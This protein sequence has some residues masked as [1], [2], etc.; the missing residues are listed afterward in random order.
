MTIEEI[1]EYL[2]HRHPFLLIDRIVSFEKG[3]RIAAALHAKS[4][5]ALTD[6]QRV[7]GE[8]E[9]NTAAVP[10]GMGTGA[11]VDSP[12]STIEPLLTNESRPRSARTTA[13]DNTMP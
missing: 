3:T 1:K 8:R 11:A 7:V 10:E 4:A 2:P 12:T 6:C 13:Y 9:P 5:V